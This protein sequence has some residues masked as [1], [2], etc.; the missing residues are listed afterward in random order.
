MLQ[1]VSRVREP[2]SSLLYCE[3]RLFPFGMPLNWNMFEWIMVKISVLFS[4]Y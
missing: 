2:L 3:S 4:I 1:Q